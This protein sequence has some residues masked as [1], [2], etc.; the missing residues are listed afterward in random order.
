MNTAVQASEPPCSSD[1][2]KPF[3]SY[4]QTFAVLD[5]DDVP[6]SVRRFSAL[7]Y[8]AIEPRH[9]ETVTLNELKGFEEAA[10]QP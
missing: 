3:K 5:P 6:T 9:I 4:H 8:Q 1:D 7:L 10:S 2:P